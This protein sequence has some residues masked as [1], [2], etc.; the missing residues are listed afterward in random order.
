MNVY[1][2]EVPYAQTDKVLLYELEWRKC[3]D[4]D[5]SACSCESFRWNGE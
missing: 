4:G 5:W 1:D 2:D 3:I